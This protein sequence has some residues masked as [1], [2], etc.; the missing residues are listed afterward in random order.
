MSENEGE[1][2]IA[3]TKEVFDWKTMGKRCLAEMFG[4]A[5]LVAIG[6]GAAILLGIFGHGND[7][8]PLVSTLAS[9]MVNVSGLSQTW[10]SDFV[11]NDSGY[12][13]FVALLIG[14]GSETFFALVF[15]FTILCTSRDRENKAVSGIALGLSLTS[16]V[17]LG[18]AITGTGVNPARSL[19]T[20]VIAL[21]N[22]EYEPIGEIWIFIVGPLLGAW[23]ATLAYHAVWHQKGAHVKPA[24]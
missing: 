23:L 7:E 1:R 3:K 2:T 15:V 22:G 6:C 5:V 12:P 11:N 18:F 16:I 19:G 17:L 4:T 14:L 21:A 20:A 9:N 13:S 10:G 8:Y 24:R